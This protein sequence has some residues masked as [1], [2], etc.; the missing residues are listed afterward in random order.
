M[1]TDID[2]VVPGPNDVPTVQPK[3]VE[4][5]L[6]YMD[7]KPGTK[8]TDIAVDVVFI[9]S[10]TNGRIE[11]LRQAAAVLRGRKV[12]KNV[13]CIVLPATLTAASRP[14]RCPL[15]TPLQVHR[16]NAARRRTRSAA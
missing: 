10:C 16:E 2:G 1:I 13:R 11:D 9:G 7:L 15:A 3:D 5:A 14:A 4:K 12:H 6:A 8:M